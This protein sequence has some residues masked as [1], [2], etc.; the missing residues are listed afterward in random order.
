M[1]KIPQLT[2]A[3]SNCSIAELNQILSTPGEM[4]YLFSDF[5]TY[6]NETYTYRF[7]ETPN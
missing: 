6:Y 4:E 5:T 2:D 7:L 1:F 3:F